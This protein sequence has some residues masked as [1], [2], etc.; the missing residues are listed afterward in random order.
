MGK[1]GCQCGY[2]ISDREI[3]DLVSYPVDTGLLALLERLR[4]VGELDY[5]ALRMIADNGNLFH[6][7]NCGRLAWEKNVGGPAEFFVPAAR[8]VVRADPDRRD[9]QGNILLSGP[10]AEEDVSRQK[11]VLPGVWATAVWDG[12]QATGLI[13]HAL[14]EHEDHIDGAWALDE[15]LATRPRPNPPPQ[16]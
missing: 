7:P 13:V 4:E 9:G 1:L 11:L 3:Q 14:D 10:E 5:S 2:A 6:C 15:H 12:G 8:P 16:A